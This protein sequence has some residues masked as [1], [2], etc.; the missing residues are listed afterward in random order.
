MTD[1][2]DALNTSA[3]VFAPMRLTADWDE[4]P[5]GVSVGGYDSLRD[6]GQQMGDAWQVDH[7]F[8][9]GFPDAV[10]LS[11]S[12]DA[13]G[14][15]SSELVGRT[16]NIADTLTGMMLSAY[17]DTGTGTSFTAGGYPSTA[18]TNDY[19]FIV[20]SVD[21]AAEVQETTYE[22]GHPHAWQL[23]A[24]VSD[25]STYTTY[26]FGRVHWS[27]A[28]LPKFTFSVSSGYNYLVS[29]MRP[30]TT[31]N[32]ASLVP[33]RPSTP[34]STA[35][36]TGTS[37]AHVGPTITVPGRGYAVGVAVTPFAAGSLTLT[38]GG[39]GVWSS[40]LGSATRIA[41]VVSDTV[42]ENS[43]KHTF[44]YATANSTAV[45][46]MVSMPFQIMDRDR[47]DAMAYFSPYDDRSPIRTFERDTAP[48]S[49]A[50]N[51]ISPNGPVGVDVFTGQMSGIAVKGRTAELEGIS[52]TRLKLD[53]SITLPTVFGRREQCTTDYLASL[54]MAHGGQ[55]VG[56]APS[57]FTRYWCPMHGS[58]HPLVAGKNEYGSNLFYDAT[59]TPKGL[60]GNPYPPVVP[61]P[62]LKGIYAQIQDQRVD[63]VYNA[64]Q[65]DKWDMEIPGQVTQRYDLCTQQ[66]SIGR[67]TFWLRGDSN[68]ASPAAL[69][70][71][72]APDYC[73][74]ASIYT[75]SGAT[76]TINLIRVQI[77]SARQPVIFLE[78]GFTLTG[79]DLPVDGLW[80]FYGFAWDYATG[81]AKVRRDNVT[82]TVSSGFVTNPLAVSEQAITDAG[83]RVEFSYNTRLPLAEFQ[84]EAGPTM[85]S[86]LFTRF[87]PTPTAPSQNA[88]YRPT[89]QRLD[90]LA[91][92]A[93]VQGW[94]TLQ[95]LAEATVSSLRVDENDN[96]MFVPME[97]FGETAQ[98]T[99]NPYN[100]LDT[101]V[102]ASELD[103]ESDPT[104]IRNIL[105][106]QYQETRVD[107]NRSVVS[108][109]TSVVD[110]LGGK[111][112]IT[113]PLEIP[114]AEIH[115]AIAPLGVD[116]D[117]KL[118]TAAQVSGASPLP[119]EHFMTPNKYDDGSAVTYTGTGISAHIMDWSNST[120]TIQF[121]NTTGSVYYLANNGSG[122][123]V[124][125]ILGYAVRRV[126]AYQ[127]MRDSSSAAKRRERALVIPNNPWI[128]NA[129]AALNMASRVITAVSNARAVTTVT[130]MGDPR[131]EPGQ[132]C[133]IADSEGTR[134]SGTWR[135]LNIKHRGGGP[136][137]LQDMVLVKV[138]PSGMWDSGL[139]DDGVW[140]E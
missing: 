101:T 36:Q 57:P 116:W 83:R 94:Q 24:R 123:P 16:T 107:L 96:V 46:M 9:D 89:N 18:V 106:V 61:G 137:Y 111:T 136:M 63:Q 29:G 95:E 17:S 1:L 56:V 99:V 31:A 58:H 11:G 19:V 3:P 128:Q 135:I 118:L 41:V 139:W 104:K 103:I 60:Y 4:L 90:A 129:D 28:P 131:R 12:S 65:T 121:T 105:T 35:V 53:K 74:Q 115:G 30:A 67:M 43:G 68:V 71:T 64:I 48:M 72:G 44:Q 25:G 86:E 49:A 51:V 138:G 54:L 39:A 117:I 50:V 80:H 8:D 122:I 78:N 42:L 113:F 124:L 87:Y 112:T 7:S 10:T 27:A 126:D 97:Y 26:V 120:V 47:L 66:N 85:Y 62:F 69:A 73:F 125:R 32:A 119:N 38:S 2:D 59:R 93:P 79:G 92:P 13:S 22:P 84:L 114:A 133:S 76:G 130:A 34:A 88:T 81:L 55:Y 132:L 40:A 37:T 91:E 82:W 52:A 140:G 70:G 45:A 98:M 102:N 134:A 108:D 33:V 15:L 21:T 75:Q 5:P 110:I 127:E 14:S 6:L 109:I 77:N 20:V 23:L 100:V